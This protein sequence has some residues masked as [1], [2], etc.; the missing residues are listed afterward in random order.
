VAL[1][2]SDAQSYVVGTEK[3]NSVTG[4]SGSEKY[5]AKDFRGDSIVDPDV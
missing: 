4:V 1:E 5:N 3:I 2:I